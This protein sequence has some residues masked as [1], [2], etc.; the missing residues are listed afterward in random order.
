MR[1]VSI[2]LCLFFFS[3][4]FSQEL[5]DLQVTYQLYFDGDIPMTYPSVLHV[6]DSVTIYQAKH[7]L[8]EQWTGGKVKSDKGPVNIKRGTIEDNYLKINHAYKEVLSF[9]L[10]PTVTELVTDNYPELKWTITNDTKTIIGYNCK[11]AF[12]SYRGRNWEAWF[13]PDI[14]VPYGPWK[15][16]GLPGLI[17]EA[18]SDNIKESYIISAVKLENSKSDILDRDFKTLVVTHNKKPVTYEQFL[19]HRDEALENTF[20]E[21]GMDFKPAKPSGYELKYEW[22]E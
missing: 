10:L 4:C 6:R 11:K 1:T 13:A 16:F 7:G 20:K 15:L 17:L 3:K 2:I 22:E 18:V 8:R 21:M 19:A 9:E 12:C 14:A 5:K